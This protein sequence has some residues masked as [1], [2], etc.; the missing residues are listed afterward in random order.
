VA[1]V[2]A[3]ADIQVLVVQAVRINIIR[4]LLLLLA[5]VV[6]EA[7]VQVDVVLEVKLQPVKAVVV[8]VYTVKD[9]V[10]LADKVQAVQEVLTEVLQLVVHLAVAEAQVILLLL[11]LKAVLELSGEMPIQAEHSLQQIQIRLHLQTQ[12]QLYKIY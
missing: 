3:P 1:A 2:A 5:V 6:L 4:G 7:A 8:L 10:V 12:K 11:E 9:R